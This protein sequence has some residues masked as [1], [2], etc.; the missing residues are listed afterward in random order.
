MSDEQLTAITRLQRMCAHY[1][2]EIRKLSNQIALARTIIK[3]YGR[4]FVGC[5]IHPKCTCGLTMAMQSGEM[6]GDET[7]PS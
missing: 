2:V 6:N 4:H 5:P 1:E 3:I 7:I